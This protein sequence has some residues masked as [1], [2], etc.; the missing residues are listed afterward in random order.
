MTPDDA[1][2]QLMRERLHTAPPDHTPRHRHETADETIR[3]TLHE[4]C[5]ALTDGAAAYPITH[6]G[7]TYTRTD[8]G[9]RVVQIEE[10]A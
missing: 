1:Y 10:H 3:R 2:A 8:N 6:P 7:H 4:L 5:R 9:P